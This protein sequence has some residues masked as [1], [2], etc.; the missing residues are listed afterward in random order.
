MALIESTAYVG[1]TFTIPLFVEILWNSRSKQDILTLEGFQA[2]GQL[3]SNPC[4]VHLPPLG[5][6]LF[7][8]YLA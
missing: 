7:V 5:S 4:M 3:T 1:S 8:H 2:P 6:L